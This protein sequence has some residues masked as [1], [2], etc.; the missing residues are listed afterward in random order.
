MWR[1]I[2]LIVVLVCV[3]AGTALA[4]TK[5]DEEGSTWGDAGWGVLTVGANLFYIPAKVLYAGA[6]AVTGG[7]AYALTVGDTDTAQKIWG[8]SLGGSYVVTPSVLRGEDPVRFSG[9]SYPNQ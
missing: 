7:L 9:P 2:C 6:G 5:K 4:Q 1:K 3:L 8:P